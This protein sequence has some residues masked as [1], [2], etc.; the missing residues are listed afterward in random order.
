MN[1]KLTG[2]RSLCTSGTIEEPE[3]FVVE[4]AINPK[5]LRKHER[6]FGKIKQVEGPYSLFILRKRN[7]TTEEALKAVSEKLSVEISFIGYAGLKDKLAVTSQYITIKDAD[8]NLNGFCEQEISLEKIGRTNRHISL[9]DLLFNKFTITLYDCKNLDKIRNILVFVKKP[10][11]NYFGPQRFSNNNVETGR[12]LLQRK[13]DLRKFSKERAKF[14][15]NSY[16]SHIF[17]IA[18]EKSKQ[19]M[20]K[21]LPLVGYDS[22]NIPPLIKKL[23]EKDKISQKDFEFG[24]FTCNGSIRQTFIKIQDFNYSIRNEPTPLGVNTQSNLQ[25]KF[26]LPKGSY[27]TIVLNKIQKGEWI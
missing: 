27:A 14:L 3:D 15:V 5:F 1:K 9:G 21:S 6:Y 19:P 7:T 4:E 26:A 22:K 17:N 13:L 16:Q 8:N 24:T 10:M 25:L 12:K 11:P 23:L 18:L 2:R 20:P